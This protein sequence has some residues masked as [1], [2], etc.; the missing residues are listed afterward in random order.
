MLASPTFVFDVDPLDPN[1]G[2]KNGST[3]PS[4]NGSTE[5]DAGFRGVGQDQ[6]REKDPSKKVKREPLQ[7]YWAFRFTY[8]KVDP[9]ILF[10]WLDEKAVAFGY[11][12]EKGKKR[13]QLH[14][15]GSFD[16][17]RTTR[18]RETPLREELLKLFPKLCFP[19]LD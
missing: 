4:N 13:G 2:S 6:S 11:Q 14:F 17:G 8:E 18:E 9:K 7:Q 3:T 15:Q 5:S 1:E 10:D 16:V 12:V 19:K